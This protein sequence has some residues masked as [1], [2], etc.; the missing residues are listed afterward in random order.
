MTDQPDP[1]TNPAEVPKV[2]EM[3]NPIAEEVPSV[4]SEEVMQDMKN[5]WAV[6][7]PENRD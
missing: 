7:D 4:I 6:F 1:T 5:I 3:G 2:D